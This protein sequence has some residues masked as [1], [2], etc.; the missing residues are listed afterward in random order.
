MIADDNGNIKDFEE[1]PPKPSSNLASMGIYIFNW[2]DTERGFDRIEG[3]AGVCFGMHVI[4]YV[5]N[6]TH[7][8]YAYEFNGYWKDV[9]TL[10]SYWQA[11][12]ELS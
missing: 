5:H 1:K 8:C 4:P 12:M 10:G 7:N 9:G 6:N 11:N 3:S 2:P